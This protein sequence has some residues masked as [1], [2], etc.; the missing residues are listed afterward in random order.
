MMSENLFAMVSGWMK[1]GDINVFVEAHPDV[2]RL[3][4]VGSSLITSFSSLWRQL[5][6]SS[7]QV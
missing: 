7:W 4:L 3:G 2:D 1:N 6:F 5:K